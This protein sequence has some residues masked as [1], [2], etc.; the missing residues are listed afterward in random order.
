ML[1]CSTAEIRSACGSGCFLWAGLFS[2]YSREGEVHVRTIF[3]SN[4]D[5]TYWPESNASG[6]TLNQKTNMIARR[7]NSDSINSVNPNSNWFWLLFV[8]SVVFIAFEGRGGYVLEGKKVL[9]S[10]IAE[11]RTKP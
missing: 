8:D 6:N 9:T 4:I 5:D 10:R 3:L 2:L 11:K 7:E 1:I